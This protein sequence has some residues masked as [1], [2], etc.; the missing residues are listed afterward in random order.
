MCGG[1]ASAHV[2]LGADDSDVG[3]VSLPGEIDD[4][5]HA[6][7]RGGSADITDGEDLVTLQQ[8]AL[9]DRPSSGVQIAKA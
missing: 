1:G 5:H 4:A 9:G 7:I 6:G 2:R 3:Q 8:V